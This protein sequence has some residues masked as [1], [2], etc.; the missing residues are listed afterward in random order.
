MAVNRTLFSTLLVLILLVAGCAKIVVPVGG[1]KDV[2]PPSVTKEHPA[3]GSTNFKGNTFKVS[4]NEYVTLNNT[5]ENV[6]ISPP[7]AMPP[8]YTLSGKTLIVKFQDTL[9]PDQTYNISFANCIQDFTEGNPLPLY[10]YAFSTGAAVDSMMVEGKVV[11]AKTMQPAKNCFVFAYTE[12]VDSLPMT[13]RP[14]FVTKTLAN[15]TFQIR[16]LKAGSYKIFVLDDE[17]NNLIYNQPTESIAFL[18]ML[19]EAVPVQKDTAV[20]VD[21]LPV[22]SVQVVSADTVKPQPLLRLFKA[23]LPQKMVKSQNKEKGKYEFV[24]SEQI[25]DVEL[26]PIDTAADFYT[27]TG[28]DTLVLYMKHELTDTLRLA[29][30]MGDTLVDTLELVPFKE[31]EART[32][33]R[34]REEKST[35]LSVTASNKG[36]LYQPLMLHFPYPVQ[37]C[38][39]VRVRLVAKKKYAGND[40]NYLWISIPDTFAMS[41]SIPATYEEKVPYELMIRDSVFTAYNGCSNDTIVLTF[42]TKTEKDYGTL[43]MLYKVPSNGVSYL[44]TLL[45]EKGVE[46]RSDKVT[47][48]EVVVYDRLPAGKY[49]VRLLEDVNGNGIWDTG[50]YKQKLLPEKVMFFSGSLSVRGYWELEESFEWKDE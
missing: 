10:S 41:L 39:S 49:K 26:H 25:G 7:P 9:L 30:M 38:D 17:D 18:P 13:T 2:T 21:S 46:L 27:Y 28:H 22:D 24:F 44:A 5:V 42:T 36:E 6:L 32:G 20:A 8:T 4:F 50:D 16:N 35:A 48:N 33:R 23:K 19:F 29:C 47:S 31:K 11:D 34:N 45:S 3:N 37:P 40:T 1:P 15:G 14:Q 12:D 43:K